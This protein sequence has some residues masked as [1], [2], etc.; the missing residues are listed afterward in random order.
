[1]VTN[2]YTEYYL[3]KIRSGPLYNI[4]YTFSYT[5]RHFDKL[6]S[7]EFQTRPEIFCS[8]QR[9]TCYLR[10]WGIS[11]WVLVNPRFL[12]RRK[13]ILKKKLIFDIKCVGWK[14]KKKTWHWRNFLCIICISF[15]TITFITWSK[16]RE[17]IWKFL[18]HFW[19]SGFF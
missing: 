18:I 10:I 6:I 15:V 14:I 11:Q 4:E 17:I 3:N 8:N 12:N 2:N 19:P 5:E 7:E 1:M 13:H 9:V 16:S